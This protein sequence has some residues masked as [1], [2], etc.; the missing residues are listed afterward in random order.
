MEFEFK[1]LHYTPVILP[2]LERAGFSWWNGNFFHYKYGLISA[3]YGIYDFN[4]RERI[5]F[6]RDGILVADSGGLQSLTQ[7][8]QEEVIKILRWQERNADIALT[9][10]ITPKV[11]LI[12]GGV[13]SWDE[14][15]RRCELSYRCYKIMERNRENDGLKLLKVL[16]GSDAKRFIYWFKR[17]EDVKMDGVCISPT[18]S[19]D[20][21]QVV[22][23][24]AYLL[25][26][27]ED[28]E[29]TY[30]H[31]LVGSPREML[32]VV[33]YAGK[34]FKLT[35]FDSSTPYVGQKFREY[36]VSFNPRIKL[37]VKRD[38]ELSTADVE[39]PCNC[40][41]CRKFRTFKDLVSSYHGL[42]LHNLYKY[43]EL[44]HLIDRAAGIGENFLLKLAEQISDQSRKALEALIYSVEEGFEKCYK[45][46]Y[47]EF[48]RYASIPRQGKLL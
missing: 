2:D 27:L 12:G 46:Y 48:M 20:P 30:L 8:W 32:P 41:V 37:N 6:P 47:T 28:E 18:I 19:K 40:P 21:F 36:I 26:R 4:F 10:D 1:H 9:F 33:A 5:K 23:Q 17:M 44:V 24:L 22:F 43:L 29:R 25:D 14:F 42:T 35:T 31:I 45:K 34:F 39:L 15:K 7:N 16:H 13:C 11:N 38:S 3:Y